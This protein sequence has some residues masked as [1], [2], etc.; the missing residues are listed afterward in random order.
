MSRGWQPARIR[1]FH[2][3]GDRSSAEIAAVE[4]TLYFYRPAHPPQSV[5]DS[6]REDGCDGNEWFE[7]REDP[8]NPAWKG[9]IAACEHELLTD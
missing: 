4:R 6:Y 3:K 7:I 9:K 1:D 2:K 8:T 5:I